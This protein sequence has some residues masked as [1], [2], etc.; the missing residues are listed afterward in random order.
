MDDVTNLLL[1]LHPGKAGPAKLRTTISLP[2]N[3]LKAAQRTARSRQVSRA[4][5][6]SDALHVG[7][8]AETG[9]ERATRVLDAYRRAFD[10]L[11]DEEAL[12]V[13][14]VIPEDLLPR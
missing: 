1:V 4:T 2:A 5:V 11:T 8:E 7:L 12:I 13:D 10:G 3:L 14:G 6:I 9:E